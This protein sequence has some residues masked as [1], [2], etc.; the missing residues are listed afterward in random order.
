MECPRCGGLMVLD[1]FQDLLD[2]A[3]QINFYGLRCLICGEVLDPL[4]LR[5]RGG[6][7]T[8]MVH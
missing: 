4:I 3:G 2:D 1:Q 8:S 5:H 6:V 7:K